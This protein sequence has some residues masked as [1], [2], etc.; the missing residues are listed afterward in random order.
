MHVRESRGGIDRKA[1]ERTD[2]HRLADKSLERLAT[3]ILEEEQGPTISAHKIERPDGPGCVKLILQ[4]V[5]VSQA[6]EDSRRRVLRDRQCDQNRPK[7]VSLTAPPAAERMLGVLPKDLETRYFTGVLLKAEVQAPNSIAPT[8]EYAARRKAVQ[9]KPKYWLPRLRSWRAAG[10]AGKVCRPLHSPR[11]AVSRHRF[12]AGP[13][14]ATGLQGE[15]KPAR[16]AWRPA[17][18]MQISR[19]NFPLRQRQK[20]RGPG[21]IRFS[22]GNGLE[23]IS[24][25]HWKACGTFARG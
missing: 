17:L 1:K 25:S 13:Y 19:I 7:A 4:I 15:A 22:W 21:S 8:L 10:T 24:G 12:T 20:R 3:G 16:S 2:F 23:C 9:P 5:F 18:R 14:I 6:V 11:Q